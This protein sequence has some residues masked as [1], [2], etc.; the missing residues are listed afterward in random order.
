MSRLLVA[1]V[2][3]LVLAFADFLLYMSAGGLDCHGDGCSTTAEVTGVLF[4]PL[5]VAA[6]GLLLALL[7]RAA[8][9]IRRRSAGNQ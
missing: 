7:V 2:L 3:V 6:A 5:L 1:V 9:M 4:S 8:L